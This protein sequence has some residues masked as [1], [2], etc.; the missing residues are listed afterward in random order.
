MSND[1]EKRWHDPRQFRRATRYTAVVIVIAAV[2]VVGAVVFGL[3]Q[4]EQCRD[5]AF[6]ICRNPE[7]L[8]LA[9]GP[10]SVLLLGGLGAFFQAFRVWRG[11][12]VWPIWQGAG[13]I[14]LVLMVAYFSVSSGVLARS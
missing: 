3:G 13:W 14:L 6:R 10:P 12:G 2:V 11:G 7:R 5:D 4:A 8:I 1:V 9:A